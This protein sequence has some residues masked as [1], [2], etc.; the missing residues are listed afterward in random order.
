[1]TAGVL[2]DFGAALSWQ[3]RRSR[4]ECLLRRG[5]AK[6]AAHLRRWGS[7]AC[8]GWGRTPAR[9][10]SASCVEPA[11]RTLSPSHLQWATRPT[12]HKR[13]RPRYNKTAILAQP[14]S[15]QTGFFCNP[16][17][18]VSTTQRKQK[19][20]KKAKKRKTKKKQKTKKTEKEK[21]TQQKTKKKAGWPGGAP[22]PAPL[23]LLPHSAALRLGA[24]GTAGS[25]GS[26]RSL[27]W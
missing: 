7:R 27:A 20:T 18:F 6:R 12:Q 9:A 13:A 11:T 17:P 23:R 26:A 4:R 10:I 19:K 25:P 24:R 2:P 21:K 14:V 8:G 3:K 5:A 22:A 16:A 15:S 1:M